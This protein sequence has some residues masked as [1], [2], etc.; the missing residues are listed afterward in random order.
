MSIKRQS[1]QV[2]VAN[3]ARRTAEKKSATQAGADAIT[4]P[5]EDPYSRL[6]RKIEEDWGARSPS[7]RAPGSRRPPLCPIPCQSLSWLVQESTVAGIRRPAWNPNKL[8]KLGYDLRGTV[9]SSE[10]AQSAS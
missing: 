3:R 7:G 10:P 8:R 6:R 2:A 5:R 9:A 1:L 4:A